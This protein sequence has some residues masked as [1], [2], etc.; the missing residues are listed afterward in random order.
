MPLLAA[1]RLIVINDI[2]RDSVLGNLQESYGPDVYSLL[3]APIRVGG[4]LVGVVCIEQFYRQRDWSIEEQNFASSLADFTA[5]AMES[6]VRR[7]AMIELD[8][9]KRRTETLMSNLP[10][11]VYQCL[12]DP[13]EFTFTFVSEGSK[14]LLGYDARELMHNSVLKFF[15]MVHPEDV[16]RLAEE[17]K[18]TLSIGLPLE[19]TFR[20]VMKDGSVKWIWERSRV[21]E[22]NPDG[23]PHLLEGFYTDITEQRRLEA[24]E[25]ANRAKTE[26]L[27]NMSHEIRTPMNAILGMTDLAIRQKPPVETLEYLR[28]IKT[29][30]NSL[31]TIINDILDFSKIEAGVI[32]IIPEKYDIISLVHDIV[33]MINVRIGEKP[34]D[35]IIDDN[36]NLPKT[37]VGDVTR[38]KQIAIN[39][40]TNAVKFTHSGF[41]KLSINMEPTDDPEKFRLKMSVQDTGIGIRKE[42]QPLL[43]GNFSQLD[44]KKNRNVEGTGLGLA[45]SKKLVEL[46]DGS[47]SV[48]SV[49]GEGSTFSFDIIQGVDTPEP[50]IVLPETSHRKVVIWMDNP[51]K[52][53]TL[54][55]KIEAMGVTADITD[56]ADNFCDYSHAFFDYGK[57]SAVDA[58][59]CTQTKLVALT[60]NYNNRSLPGQV[61][62]IYT[63]LTSAVVAEIL[64]EKSFL[65]FDAEEAVAPETGLAFENT[66]VLVVDDNDINLLIAENVLLTYCDK[67]TLA[68]S[69]E[70]ALALV[71]AHE[72][73]I[74]FMDHM[75]PVMDGVDATVLIREMPEQRC[76]TMP[77]V[78]LTANAVGDVREM[79][80]SHGMNDFLSK[81]LE[82]KEIERV[83]REWMPPEKRRRVS[84]NHAEA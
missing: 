12:N 73:D 64:S 4:E 84:G 56:N 18:H 57:F 9:S 45:I 66:N 62:T 30:A 69:G 55:N 51:L 47:I 38:V 37:L 17:N 36:P 83:L 65:S 71:K 81:P 77:I 48:E 13:P 52:A 7:Q 3:D 27:A 35:F 70:E 28:N 8:L 31:L 2:R 16:D 58:K 53:Q 63:P 79:F 15:D 42:D 72:Y 40:L 20:M 6:A 24:A 23:S 54:K 46:M 34:I 19:T 67:V 1:E 59:K 50:V 32:E 76:K 21:V 74:V 41:V 78:A 61:I 80:L 82:I 5:L 29:A 22:R 25:L 10:G 11:M 14:Q 75:M 39:L 43:F 44:T 60:R 49:Y 26:F 33:T 68:K